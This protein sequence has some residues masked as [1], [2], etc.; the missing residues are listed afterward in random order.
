MDSNPGD[1]GHDA[2]TNAGS[3]T[4]QHVTGHPETASSPVDEEPTADTP[5]HGS[6][7]AGLNAANA[8]D[9]GR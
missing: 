9:A 4:D 8:E 2:S 7:N 3:S 1:S 5:P 6:S